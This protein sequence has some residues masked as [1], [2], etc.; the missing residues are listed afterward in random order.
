MPAA[1]VTSA[2][3]SG[4]RAEQ[5]LDCQDR[6]SGIS[7]HSRHSVRWRTVGGGLEYVQRPKGRR[8]CLQPRPKLDCW[9]TTSTGRGSGHLPGQPRCRSPATGEILARVPL[10]GSADVDAAVAAARA[11]SRLAQ[12]LGDRARPLA[13]RLS[14]GAGGPPGRGCPFGHPRDGEDFADARAEVGRAIEMIEAATAVPQTMQGRVLENVA[15]AVDCETI[16]Q[17]VGVCAAI[18]PSTSRRWCPS[19]S[20]RSRSRAATPSC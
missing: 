14:P 19:G 15:T 5:I 3:C 7:D 17:P 11:A 2:S 18:C 8:A 16:R 9:A 1:T 4:S 13:V 12:A 10:S 6:V 20:C